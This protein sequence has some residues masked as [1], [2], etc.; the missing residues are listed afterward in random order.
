VLELWSKDRLKRKDSYWE[1]LF[2]TETSNLEDTQVLMEPGLKNT[3]AAFY[4]KQF[5]APHLYQESRANMHNIELDSM[6]NPAWNMMPG[7]KQQ[8]LMSTSGIV[9]QKGVKSQKKNGPVSNEFNVIVCVIVLLGGIA[10]LA[11]SKAFLMETEAHLVIISLFMFCVLELGRNHLVSYFWFLS[12]HL[13]NV[14]SSTEDK[15]DRVT[16]LSNPQNRRHTLH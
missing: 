16:R 11:M 8:L 15:T 6:Y 13:N 5:A 14:L 9:T 3:D 1:L 10:N 7:H 12:A 4:V 2:A